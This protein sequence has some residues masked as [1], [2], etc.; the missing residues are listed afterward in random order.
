MFP[1]QFRFETQPFDF[2]SVAPANNV[3][4]SVNRSPSSASSGNSDTNYDDT[5]ANAADATPNGASSVTVSLTV[6]GGAL[7]A[8]AALF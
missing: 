1:H 5:P 6:L 8:A 4:S 7:F 3:A 2:R